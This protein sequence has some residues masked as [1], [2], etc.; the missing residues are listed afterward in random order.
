M[1][2]PSFFGLPLYV[3]IGMF[4]GILVIL[5]VGIAKRWIKV[6]MKWHRR[7]GWLILF[8]GLIHGGLGIAAYV[9]HVKVQGF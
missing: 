6:N 9:F 1:Y 2:I 8:T 7:N 3:W 4:L 5:Q